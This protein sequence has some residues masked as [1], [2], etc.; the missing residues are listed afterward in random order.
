MLTSWCL[1]VIAIVY[2]KQQQTTNEERNPTVNC[3]QYDKV[4]EQMVL[5]DL[6]ETN[7]I[8]LLECYCEADFTYDWNRSVSARLDKK[9]SDGTKHCQDWMETKI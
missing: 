8:G 4:T 1:A 7:K 9:F 3:S 2:L 6:E 5:A